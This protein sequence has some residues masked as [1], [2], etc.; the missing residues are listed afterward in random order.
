MLCDGIRM[1]IQH[2]AP[3]WVRVADLED[4]GVFSLLLFKNNQKNV[5]DR[6]DQVSAAS[7]L[8]LIPAI[9]EHD[10]DGMEEDFKAA[11]SRNKDPTPNRFS[12]LTSLLGWSPVGFLFN[13]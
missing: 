4:R 13:R 12:S 1:L 10:P 5:Q 9:S 8:A 6:L 11:E 7:L 3:R 2:G